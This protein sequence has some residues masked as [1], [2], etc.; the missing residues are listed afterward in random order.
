MKRSM[1]F[2]EL[3]EAHP[4]PAK[5]L[6]RAELVMELLEAGVITHAQGVLM[7]NIPDFKKAV[8]S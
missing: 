5:Q 4:L 3:L 2:V 7:L 1:T 6:D 8:S